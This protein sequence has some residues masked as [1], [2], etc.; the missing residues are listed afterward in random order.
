MT[1]W[2]LKLVSLS[3]SLSHAVSLTEVAGLI[4]LHTLHAVMISVTSTDV[5][6]PPQQEMVSS[7]PKEASQSAGGDICC[8]LDAAL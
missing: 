6:A 7:S 5:L 3:L 8:Y 4:T 2:L 1:G